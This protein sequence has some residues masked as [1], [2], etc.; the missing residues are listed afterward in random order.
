MTV[1]RRGKSRVKRHV[2]GADDVDDRG[3]V[4]QRR[5]ADEDVDLADGNQLPEQ[6]V[7][8]DALVLHV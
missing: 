8:K 4:V 7:G 1:R 5:Q 2:H 3:G 6:R